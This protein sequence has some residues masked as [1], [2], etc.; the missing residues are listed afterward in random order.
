MC[1]IEMNSKGLLAQFCTEITTRRD[2]EG[3]KCEYI[4][5]VLLLQK[6]LR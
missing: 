2:E 3:K 4:L 6:Q 5:I 1:L